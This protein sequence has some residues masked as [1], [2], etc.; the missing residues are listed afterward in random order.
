MSGL[1]IDATAQ[2]GGPADG[3]VFGATLR[4]AMS[5]DRERVHYALARQHVADA[6]A[7][8]VRQR[9]ILEALRA[10]GRVTSE[11]QRMHEAMLRLLEVMQVNLRL[12]EAAL[13]RDGQ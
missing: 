13:S 11:A 10:A 3:R 12:I 1:S 4:L 9:E 5:G 6:E 2:A 8:I 7:R